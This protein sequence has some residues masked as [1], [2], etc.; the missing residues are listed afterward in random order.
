MVKTLNNIV[1][2]KNIEKKKKDEVIIACITDLCLEPYFNKALKESLKVYNI[3]VNLHYIDYYSFEIDASIET[4]CSS[5]IL[6]VILSKEIFIQE[7]VYSQQELELILSKAKRDLNRLYTIIDSIFDGVL[8][9]IGFEDLK[10]NDKIFHGYL[11]VSDFFVDKLNIFIY[12]LIYNESIFVDFKRII[13]QNGV[14]NSYNER[15]KRL[16]N[17]PYSKSLIYAISDEVRKQYL[18]E[19]GKSKKCLILDCDNVLWGGILSEDGFE[20][21]VLGNTVNGYKYNIFQKFVKKLIE[22]GV[23][24]A[25]CSKNDYSCVINVFRNHTGMI[26]KES[27]VA[28]FKVNWKEK[29]NNIIEISEYLNIGLDSIVFIDDSPLEINNVAHFLPEVTAILFNE[30]I[31]KHLNCFNL[32]NNYNEKDIITRNNVLK[33]NKLRLEL[34]EKLESRD[35]YL[36]ELKVEVDIHKIKNDEI[37]RVSELT[38]RVNRCTNGKRYTKKQIKKIIECDNYML[39]SVF[40]KDCFSNLGLIGAIGIKDNQLDLF[41]LSC[42]ALGRNIEAKMLKF[43]KQYN[44]NDFSVLETSKNQETIKMISDW[45]RF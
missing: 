4:I 16:W 24:L 13:S 17:S 35:E 43:I 45:F 26:I 15:F 41:S 39:F 23:I 8:I 31:F 19:I 30:E 6:L 10:N 29:A 28:I 5:D 21:I 9:W 1:N 37:A 32:K 44:I 20:G 7:K 11:P 38:Q 3:D 2:I 18:I 33:S 40:A 27:D 36:Q 25:I 42:R 22:N 34:K 14:S 12:E